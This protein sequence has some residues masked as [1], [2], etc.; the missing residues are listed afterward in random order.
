MVPADAEPSGAVTA[1][2]HW[3]AAMG[4]DCCL[5]D[6]P[7]AFFNDRQSSH[8]DL[9]HPGSGTR[10]A[11]D[12]TPRPPASRPLA[13]E[14]AA[15]PVSL[16]FGHGYAPNGSSSDIIQGA[17]SLAASCSTIDALR[18]ALESFE[19]C[20][21][22]RT[23]NRLCFGDGN[24]AA[25]IMLIGEAPGAEED[26]Q[27]KPFVGPSGRLLDRM[28]AAIGL[29]RET[30]WI[31]NAIFWRPPGNRTPTANEIAVC[32]PFVERQ[33]EIMAPEIIV[34]VGGI[35]ARTLLGTREGVTRLRGR[36]FSYEPGDGKPAI[37]AMVMFHPAYLLR[38]P[39]RKKESWQDL[40]TVS[41]WLEDGAMRSIH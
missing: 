36:R 41:E 6:S 28:L 10:P 21:L 17:R 38:Q 30:V 8:F 23:A 14:P 7:T 19:G 35:A 2:L 12:D 9:P 25:S 15:G 29:G 11:L 26:R 40:M 33:I 20:A 34:F 31:T 16:P 13:A 32:Q 18:T 24:P 3:Y 4:V 22:K 27:G 37:P 39:A 5:H 1:W